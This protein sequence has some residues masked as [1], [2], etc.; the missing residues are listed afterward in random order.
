[1]GSRL[2]RMEKHTSLL[3]NSHIHSNRAL[4]I[5]CQS[6]ISSLS[7]SLFTIVSQEVA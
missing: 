5:S 2:Y 7:K 6:T 4:L 3:G 1:M